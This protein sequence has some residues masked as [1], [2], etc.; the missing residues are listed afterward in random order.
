MYIFIFIVPH[1]IYAPTIEI[2]NDTIRFD[3]RKKNILA[4]IQKIID[5]KSN[6]NLPLSEGHPPLWYTV[7]YGEYE[8]SHKLLQCGAN[9]DFPNYSTSPATP[10][11]KSVQVGNI[12]ILKLLL[13]YNANPDKLT[14]AG[15]TYLHWLCLS[16]DYLTE[17]QKINAA[18]LL[19]NYGASTK[20]RSLS[21]DNFGLSVLELARSKIPGSN[22][23][24]LI[25]KYSNV[26]KLP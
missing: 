22:L 1:F 14:A 4:I 19:L 26:Q 8:L 5:T 23:L 11:L 16:H 24:K 21:I 17:E 6:P 20:I 7:L 9:P 12:D 25:E 10:L 18:Q 2:L 3:P 13:N 15:N